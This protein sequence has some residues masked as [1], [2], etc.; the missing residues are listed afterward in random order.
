MSWPLESWNTE[1]WRDVVAEMRGRADSWLEAGEE[2][3]DGR[4]IECLD[5]IEAAIGRGDEALLADLR[6][7]REGARNDMREFA[8][9]APDA[10]PL[11]GL[12]GQMTLVPLVAGIRFGL[13]MAI[14]IVKNRQKHPTGKLPFFET[15]MRKMEKRAGG[16]K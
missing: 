1:S 14:L 16:A 3:P 9:K 13:T 6:A 2:Q 10:D 11:V 4:L 5:R 7:M 8:K 12:V 15:V